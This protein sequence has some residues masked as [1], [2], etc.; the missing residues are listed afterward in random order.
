MAQPNTAEIEKLFRSTVF[1]TS[2]IINKLKSIK[3]VLFF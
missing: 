3:K 1:G 2:L